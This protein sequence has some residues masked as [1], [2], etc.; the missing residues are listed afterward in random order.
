MNFCVKEDVDNARMTEERTFCLGYHA[1]TS[2]LNHV[3][4][5]HV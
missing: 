1:E 3:Y 5:N 2:H 4:W